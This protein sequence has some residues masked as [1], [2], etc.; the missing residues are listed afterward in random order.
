MNTALIV[1]AT[2]VGIIFLLFGFS[3]IYNWRDEQRKKKL[4]GSNVPKYKIEK[5]TGRLTGNVKYLVHILHDGTVD[6]PIYY[7]SA[8]TD[9]Y[10]E[11]MTIAKERAESFHS[12]YNKETR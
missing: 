1:A 5:V 9:N 4:F 6:R 7:L 12:L 2:I 3:V 11:A 10:E 8:S